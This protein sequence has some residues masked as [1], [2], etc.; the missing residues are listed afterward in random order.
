MQR[1][2]LQIRASA[3]ACELTSRFRGCDGSFR[4]LQ[5]RWASSAD[6]MSYAIAR[7]VTADRELLE[8]LQRAERELRDK[9]ASLTAGLREREVLLQ[10]IHHR[11]KNNL[12]VISSL[13]NMQA[14]R[15]DVPSARS[16]LEE[17]KTRVE[18]IALIHEQLYQSNDYR[19][20]PFAKYL[21]VLIQSITSMSG[22]AG[23]RVTLDVDTE[24]V[25]LPVD[26]AI[27]CGLILNELITNALKH[28]YPGGR[29]GEVRVSLH[30]HAG[31]LA[32][33]VADDGIGL[34]KTDAT[35]ESLGMQLIETL[36]EQIRGELT[37]T[38]ADGMTFQV[39][40]PLR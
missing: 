36:V 3:S 17:C 22:D 11:V 30:Q 37:V 7:D 40:C 18:A 13:I 38:H 14:R 28:A 34:S 15:L 35:T 29:A 20:I 4:W 10:E 25:A 5:W 21:K 26:K 9:Q 16:A 33:V 1:T 24:P 8:S 39:T 2:L 12:Q 23:R 27:P 32:L 31:Q 19:Q 6:G